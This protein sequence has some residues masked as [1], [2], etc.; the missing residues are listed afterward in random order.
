MSKKKFQG[1]WRIVEM[2]LW[3]QDFICL[4]GPGYIRFERDGMG[5]FHFGAVHGWTDCRYRKRDGKD[6][7]EFSWEGNEESNPVCGRG[8]VVLEG[9]RLHGRLFF[10]QGDDSGFVAERQ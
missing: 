5:D 9:D 4:E 7:V 10:H 2:E 6:A 8:W 1:K 3:D